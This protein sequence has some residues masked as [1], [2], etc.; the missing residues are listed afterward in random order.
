MK[1]PRLIAVAAAALIA[2]PTASAKGPDQA[3]ITG[4]GL[5]APIVLSGDAESNYSSSFGQF[6]AGTGF[7]PAVFHQQP[8]PMSNRRPKGDLGPRYTIVYRVPAGELEAATVRQELYPYA[9]V[10]AVTYMRPG[11]RMFGGEHLT[12]GGWFVGGNGLK[13]T[14]TALG[15]PRTASQTTVAPAQA[16]RRSAVRWLPLA[17]A[18]LLVPAAALAIRRRR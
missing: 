11:Q 13:Q 9:A 15:L 1:T 12:R 6:V 2:T 14:L 10:G 3:T 8:D 16:E 18:G 5:D 4:P 7:M 17:F